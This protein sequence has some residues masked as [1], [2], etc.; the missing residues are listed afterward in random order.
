[1]F[2]RKTFV[3]KTNEMWAIN[4]MPFIWLLS[5]DIFTGCFYVVKFGF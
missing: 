4:D 2:Y 3:E 5:E 1:M